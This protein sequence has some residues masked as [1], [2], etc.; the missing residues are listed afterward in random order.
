M[1]ERIELPA[2]P[3]SPRL[4]RRFVTARLQHWGYSDLAADAEIVTS[5]LVTNVVRHLEAPLVVEV[6]DLGDSILIAVVDP[7]PELPA[8]SPPE[9][10]SPGG[11]GLSIVHELAAAWGAERT[12]ENGKV[13]WVRLSVDSP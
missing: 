9:P 11:R 10:T 8:I 5:E 12:P 2:D 13:V 7:G 3:A 1:P 6:M 4:A